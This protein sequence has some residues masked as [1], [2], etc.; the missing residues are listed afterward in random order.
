M[1]RSELYT[2]LTKSQK[3]NTILSSFVLMGLI[4]VLSALIA[5]FETEVQLNVDVTHEENQQIQ[6]KKEDVVSE[7]PRV[8]LGKGKAVDENKKSETSPFDELDRLLD[9]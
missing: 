1:K 3:R 2:T 4:V 9:K 5:G 7:V 8:D 6:K